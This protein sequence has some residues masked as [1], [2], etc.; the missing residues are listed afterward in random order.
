[1][2]S[3][4]NKNYRWKELENFVKRGLS[5]DKT[6]H[7]YEHVKR[8]LKN[9]LK[10]AKNYKRINYNVL[11]AS[12]LL[13]DIAFKNGFV[14]NHH[15]VGAKQVKSILP[16]FG[17]KQE[18]IDEISNATFLHCGNITGT[19]IRD[20]KKMSI[21][22]KILRDADNIDALGSIGLIRMIDFCKSQNLPYFKSKKDGLND[23]IYGGVKAVIIWADSMLTIPGKRIGKKRIKIMKDF[24]EEME[25]EF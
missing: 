4:L 5:K 24:L 14:K 15:I 25:F 3:K 10:I 12:C 11:L 7:D 6:G 2:D 19:A 20:S 1:M 13:H 22:A 9:S 8:V 18:E 23:S 16:K 21:E 17:F